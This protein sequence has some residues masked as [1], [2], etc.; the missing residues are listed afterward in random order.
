MRGKSSSRY[1][2]A[3]VLLL[4]S[5]LL[6][7]QTSPGPVVEPPWYVLHENQLERIDEIFYGQQAQLSR[8]ATLLER[9]ATE[10]VEAQSQ[11]QTALSQL[12]EA[13]IQSAEAL[14]RSREAGSLLTISQTALRKA[15]TSSLQL[16]EGITLLTRQRNLAIA[17][18]AVLAVLAVWQAIR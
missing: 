14:T 1:L 11:L 12:D 17:G 4:L 13:Q 8:Q 18:S 10:S 15:E 3:S 7:S 6:Y 9:A 16:E 2:L 5:P